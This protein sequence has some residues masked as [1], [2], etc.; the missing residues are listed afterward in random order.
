[1]IKSGCNGVIGGGQCNLICNTPYSFIGGGCHHWICAST[2]S[3]GTFGCGV[4]GG[5]YDHCL[6]A[7]HMAGIFSGQQSCIKCSNLSFIGGGSRNC[8][9]GSNSSICPINA[10]SGGLSNC[11]ENGSCNSFIGAGYCN[12][13]V[14]SFSTI[15]GG[16]NF[17]SCGGST[18][19]LGNKICSDGSFIGGGQNNFIDTASG[20]SVIG[21][22]GGWCYSGGSFTYCGNC[23]KG[24]GSFIGGGQANCIIASC[25]VIG[26]GYCN[27]V[28]GDYSAILGGC[29]NSVPAGCSYVGIFGCNITA[30]TNKAFHANTFVA[31]NMCCVSM[32][33]PT[34]CTL[35]YCNCGIGNCPV[36]IA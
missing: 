24:E 23:I 36:Y 28:C 2:Y 26:G 25:S 13:I 22:G 32:S 1:M 34:A 18:R 20:C 4:V 29:C 16:G 15:S 3:S 12:C 33:L 30:V 5:G 11:I 27:L 8:I 21:G 14:G 17:N 6:I 10:I 35:Y 9:T 7:S 19:L 31:T